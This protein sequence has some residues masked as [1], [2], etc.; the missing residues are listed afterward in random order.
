MKAKFNLINIPRKFILVID[1]AICTVSVLVAYQLRFNF[2]V[3]T[4]EW[5]IFP[6]A[7]FSILVARSISLLGFKIYRSSIRFSGSSDVFK[8]TGALACSALMVFAANLVSYWFREKYLA[9]KSIIIIEFLVSTF[10]MVL[11]RMSIR[12]LYN[13]MMN[14]T[15]QKS[16]VIIFGA[17]RSGQIAKRSLDRDAGSRFKVFAFVD[18]NKQLDKLIIEGVPVYNTFDKLEKLLSDNEIK[19]LIIAIQNLGARRKA[20]V[21]GICLKYNTKVLDVPPVKSWINGELSFKQIKKIKVEDL[22]ERDSIVL[23]IEIIK[24][25]LH[26]KTILITGA[27]GSIGSEIVRQLLT[28]EPQHVVMVDNAESALY[29][30][31]MEILDMQLQNIK[32]TRHLADIRHKESMTRIFEYH[33]P[34]IVFHAA[35]YKHVPMMEEN[36]HEAINTNVVGT[37]ILADCAIANGVEKF[38][39]VSTDKAVNPTNVMGASKRIAEIYCQTNNNVS[40]TKFITTRFGNVLGS[41]GSVIPLFKKQIEEGKSIKVTHPEITRYFMTI[42]EACQLVLEAG[43][44]GNGGEIFVFDM[45]TPVKIADL[46]KKMITLYGLKLGRDIEINYTGLRP[47]EKLYEE[48]LNDNESVLPTHHSKIMKAKVPEYDYESVT[49]NMMELIAINNGEDTMAIVQKMKS[50]VPEYISN[51]SEFEILD[52]KTN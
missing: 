28:F 44:I 4:R 5:E 8:I 14:P 9:P 47:G 23:D 15:S 13:E 21:A 6:L 11:G 51:N 42:R 12:A 32:V 38:V 49:K 2:A 25:Q 37:K 31:E 30:I 7:L 3:P 40:N 36:V 35:A 16:K 1:L 29:D 18:D 24:A 20:E 46:A 33:K 45:G 41:N 43:A 22:L 52:K 34:Q 27:A 19:H 17:G 26:Q 39:M 10:V 50:M 48:L